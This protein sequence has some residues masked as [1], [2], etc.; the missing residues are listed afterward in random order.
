[1]ILVG[2]SAVLSVDL[3]SVSDPV[4]ALDLA[5]HKREAWD[6]LSEYFNPG[7]RVIVREALTELPK[8]LGDLFTDQQKTARAA[9][10]GLLVLKQHF[11]EPGN[12]LA[13]LSVAFAPYRD[14][15]F[16]EKYYVYLF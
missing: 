14:C 10:T 3:F 7:E 15:D 5:F 12:E 8:P 2:A 16:P 6:R 9:V 4:G 1:L 13:Q 11:S